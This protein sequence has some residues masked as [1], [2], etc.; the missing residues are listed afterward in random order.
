MKIERIPLHLK[1]R[2]RNNDLHIIGSGP[3]ISED[4]LLSLKHK[5]TFVCNNFCQSGRIVCPSFSPKFICIGDPAYLEPSLA[6]YGGDPSSFYARVFREYPGITI[7]TSID[8]GEFIYNK[9]KGLSDICGK[10]YTSPFAAHEPPCPA[11]YHFKLDQWLQPYQNILGMALQ[12]AGYFGASNIYLHGFE[13]HPL[14]TYPPTSLKNY[15]YSE[16]RFIYN[17]HLH[18]SATG[19]VEFFRSAYLVLL[20][21]SQIYSDLLSGGIKVWNATPDTLIMTFPTICMSGK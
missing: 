16:E 8:I 10:I 2:L 7:L 13:H 3:S 21:Y 1:G 14:L 5:T 18:S 17:H 4:L 19:Q 20:Q 15:F 6:D 12:F 11:K 9:V